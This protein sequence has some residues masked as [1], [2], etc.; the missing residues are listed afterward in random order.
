MDADGVKS[1]L[2]VFSPI[3]AMEKSFAVLREMQGSGIRPDSWLHLKFI[4]SLVLG[5]VS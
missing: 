2:R 5:Y 1:N 4:A 3:L